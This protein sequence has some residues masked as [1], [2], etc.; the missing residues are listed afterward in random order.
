MLHRKHADRRHCNSFHLF[1]QLNAEHNPQD[2]WAAEITPEMNSSYKQTVCM[3]H[4][5]WN[6]THVL[7]KTPGKTANLLEPATFI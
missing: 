1:S 7:I 3:N 5:K 2:I 4:L 6:L